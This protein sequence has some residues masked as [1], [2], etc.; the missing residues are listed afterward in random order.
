MAD[1][2][3]KTVERLIKLRKNMSSLEYLS[4]VKKDAKPERMEKT[5]KDIDDILKALKDKGF[6]VAFPFSRKMDEISKAITQDKAALTNSLMAKA[7]PCWEKIKE[8]NA[9]FVFYLGN[10]REITDLNNMMN[11]LPEAE[12]EKIKAAVESGDLAEEIEISSHHKEI[13]KALNRIGI[14]C[15][16]AA[17]RI[18]KG[19]AENRETKIFV[20]D[21]GLW[22]PVD[23][24]DMTSAII[25]EWEAV[26]TQIQIKNAKRQIMQFDPGEEKEFEGLQLRYLEMIKK[27]DDIIAKYGS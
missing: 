1:V 9:M 5:R 21:R 11:R 19:Q 22:I 27:V 23:Q 17:N 10:V 3:A 2:E 13:E 6:I 26:G 7:G 20:K 4:E 18:S 16:S 25:K 14:A 8:K 15:V 24:K 12:R